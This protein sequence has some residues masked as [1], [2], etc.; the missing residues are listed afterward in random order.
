MARSPRPLA[1]RPVFA[2]I[3]PLVVPVLATGC[4]AP[5]ASD[6][7][8]SA[9]CGA[10]EVIEAVVNGVAADPGPRALSVNPNLPPALPGATAAD[11]AL[12]NAAIAVFNQPSR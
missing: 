2:L 10:P 7:G 3:L 1:F 4:D 8:A 5:E 6:C 9:G 12:F 11:V